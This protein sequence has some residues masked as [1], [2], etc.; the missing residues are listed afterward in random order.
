M[1]EQTLN[2]TE[3]L[4]NFTTIYRPPSTSILRFLSEFG[5]L[6]DFLQ[7]LPVATVIS[8]DFNIHVEAKNYPSNQ[9]HQLLSDKM[10]TQHVDF[11]TNLYDYILDLLITPN[12]LVII[13]CLKR[14]DC[15]TD[16]FAITCS[17]N[18]V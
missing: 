2:K 18:V 14:S 17:L 5:K 15:L 6:L 4:V 8:G 10:L 11:I 7:S 3:A 12:D 13:S 9:F 1:T 16:H